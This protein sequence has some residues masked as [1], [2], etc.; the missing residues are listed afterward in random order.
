RLNGV[1]GMRSTGAGV[2]VLGRLPNRC[3]IWAGLSL[4]QSTTNAVKVPTRVADR[5]NQVLM[6]SPCGG[7]GCW[8]ALAGAG[9]ASSQPQDGI[10]KAYLMRRAGAKC[11]P[12]RKARKRLLTHVARAADWATIPLLGEGCYKW[13]SASMGS[14]RAARR[15]G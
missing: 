12:N 15:A 1:T 14:M 3:R 7:M 6:A 4:V 8:V 9:N 10:P 13:R 2:G 5:K 11:W